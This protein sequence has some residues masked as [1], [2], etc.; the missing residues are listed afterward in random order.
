MTARHALI[1]SLC[2]YT[3]AVRSHGYALGNMGLLRV[4][5]WVLLNE[6]GLLC[7]TGATVEVYLPGTDCL[8]G[9]FSVGSDS[10]AGPSHPVGKAGRDAVKKAP[11]G[12]TM[13]ARL[14][15]QRGP[16]D[17]SA[18]GG[19]RWWWACFPVGVAARCGDRASGWPDWHALCVFSS[20]ARPRRPAE[21]P[22]ESLN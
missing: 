14:Y 8:A 20:A 11:L 9:S 1:G 6:H 10:G 7:M 18:A 5:A 2:G 17:F 16:P 19:I 12:V 21:K 22:V 13:M 15:A 3:T 4:A